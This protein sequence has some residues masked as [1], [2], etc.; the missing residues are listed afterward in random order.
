MMAGILF[1]GVTTGSSLVHRARPA[2]QPLLGQACRLRGA[3]IPLG[4]D[5]ETY[6]SLLDDLR[7]D[8]GVAGAVV[9]THKVRLPRLGG[10]VTAVLGLPDD[11]S[12]GDRFAGAAQS[13]RPA[14]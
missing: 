10:G 1:V 3:D 7:G 13:L 9:T 11:D 8:N 14:T 4:A 5:D 6:L 12:L 2:W